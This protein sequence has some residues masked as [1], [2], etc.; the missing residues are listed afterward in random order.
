MNSAI[1]YKTKK[2]TLNLLVHA[3]LIS[4]AIT[5]LYPLLWMIASS[6][7]TQETIFSDIS[8]IPKQF[9]FENYYLA[10]SQNDFG[11]YF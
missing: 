9:H 3:F 11:R 4:M 2:I 5:C 6:F 8:L 10:V 1:Y 7:K